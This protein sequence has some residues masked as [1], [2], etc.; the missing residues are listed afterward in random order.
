MAIINSTELASFNDEIQDT[1]NVLA[2]NL[3]AAECLI[4]DHERSEDEELVAA[5]LV[6]HGTRD[7]MNELAARVGAGCMAAAA[8]ATAKAHKTAV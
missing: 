5:S 1:L 7:R 8:V 4:A 2:A 6:L 3:R